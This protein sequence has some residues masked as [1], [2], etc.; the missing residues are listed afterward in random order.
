MY[1]VR[2]Y[3]IVF[4]FI[5]RLVQVQYKTCSYIKILEFHSVLIAKMKKTALQLF[6]IPCTCLA[7]IVLALMLRET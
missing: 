1:Y 7:A 2:V 5:M 6:E 3:N 4:V